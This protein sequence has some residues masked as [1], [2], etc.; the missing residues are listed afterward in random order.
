MIVQKKYFCFHDIAKGICSMYNISRCQAAL[1]SGC[2]KEHGAETPKGEY[3]M[4]PNFY[5]TLQ[6][7]S[8]LNNL[9]TL[10][11]DEPE[12]ELI[13][14]LIDVPCWLLYTADASQRSLRA[15]MR[16]EIHSLDEEVSIG[17][18]SVVQ[19]RVTGERT[20][21]ETRINGLEILFD[22]CRR[23]H[24]Y[25]RQ[26]NL[27][28]IWNDRDPQEAGILLSGEGETLD[29]RLVEGAQRPELLCQTL[30]GGTQMMRP[31]MEDFWA[32]SMP[33]M[34]SLEDRIEAAEAGDEHCI[35]A[36]AEAYFNGDEEVDVDPE[37]CVYWYE[38]LAETGDSVAQFNMGLFCAK[39]FGRARDMSA[40]LRW[41][42]RAAE[43]GDEDAPEQIE[44]YRLMQ[45]AE[46]GVA[47]GDAQAQA[48]MA[49]GLMKL[50]G[51][52][53]PDREN[54]Y[55]ECIA[56]AEKSAAQNN[57]DGLWLMAL[58][59]EH[60]R[61][62][63][64]NLKKAAEY[65]QRGT[66]VGHAPCMSSL[67]SMC[68]NG[69]G[70]EKNVEKG[71][72]LTQKSA[73][74]GDGIGMYNLG[75]CYQFGTGVEESLEKAV[76]WYEKSLEV[77]PD[78]ELEMKLV[79]FRHLLEIQSE[80]PEAPDDNEMTDDLLA[81][82]KQTMHDFQTQD[83][84]LVKYNGEDGDVEIPFGLQEIGARAFAL[85]DHL[86]SVAVT[87]PIRRI[88]DK[89]FIGC[90]ALESVTLPES[91]QEI[92]SYG[93][94]NCDKVTDF[95]LPAGLTDIGEYAFVNCY[96][97]T[98]IVIPEG[99][100]EISN[101]A[102]M[103]C[104]SLERVVLPEGLTRIGSEAF[105]GCVALREMNIPA[106]LTSVGHKAFAGCEQL[107]NA[108]EVTEEK[109]ESDR[110]DLNDFLASLFGGAD[111]EDASDED[112]ADDVAAE[113]DDDEDAEEDEADSGERVNFSEIRD[114]RKSIPHT[115][116]MLE[117]MN[118]DSDTPVG[119]ERGNTNSVVEGAEYDKEKRLL[120]VIAGV[121]GIGKAAVPAAE[122]L[123]PGQ[124]VQI[125]P[126]ENEIAVHA[127]GMSLGMLST[128]FSRSLSI[129]L[130]AG[131][132]EVLE[133][134]VTRVRTRAERGPRTRVP[135]LVVKATVRFSEPKPPRYV[136]RKTGCT[137]CILGGDQAKMWA[138]KLRVLHIDLPLETAKLVFELYNR[139][140]SEYETDPAEQPD[141]AGLD[142]LDRE[143]MAA[144]RKMQAEMKPGLDYSPQTGD[145][146]DAFDFG[147][148]ITRMIA[149]EPKRYG[150]LATLDLEYV[151][152]PA[153]VLSPYADD[154]ATFCWW[155]LTRISEE[156][157]EAA[158][159]DYNHWYDVCELYGPGKL[160]F[161]LQ[162][163]DVVSIFGFDR[164]VA[165]ADLSYGC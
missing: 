32:R 65:Y 54:D 138:Q 36:L 144:R 89:A 76:E 135:V 81:A 134:R 43:S 108:P 61:G 28:Q 88:G 64:K 55:A 96:G 131:E 7:L 66:D 110:D 97:L 30:L 49:R 84:V 130:K 94:A 83:A 37:K 90:H 10:V 23:L 115:L 74:L 79:G 103:D 44:T 63:R 116:S 137:L 18:G 164:F 98:S 33:E 118:K 27:L 133:A 21:E 87:P 67:G 41:M 70:V 8:G 78:P 48:D 82:L 128:S 42:E 95:D 75:R 114:A 19:D 35:R 122:S 2:L 158:C 121:V 154:E 125:V 73:M 160:P 124:N 53:L 151:M 4:R 100:Q 161:D 132:A 12:V 148:Y 91:L 155:D 146:D 59:Y 142:N 102:F 143:I 127:S 51:V 17:M 34:V 147:G 47:A 156:D 105:S 46:S 50:G 150:V 136:P 26:E 25:L 112:E 111:D 77:R 106:S 159:D 149:R 20:V 11:E 165:F 69:I 68:L 5:C 6:A 31:Y 117:F 29:Y 40:A 38:K 62:V 72:E 99:V 56:L 14:E 157:F 145:E 52:N 86:T 45:E 15:Y 3:M 162:D 109:T 141:Y 104:R 140:H 60:G 139:M 107:E 22:L 129:L 123:R 163:E 126:E 9:V 113:C 1:A 58:A 101:G 153:A 92:A 16:G 80:M 39:G 57:G 85:C 120:T 24:V 71:I 13:V 152:D 119:L 93:F